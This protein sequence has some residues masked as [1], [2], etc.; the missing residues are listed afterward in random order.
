ME[1]FSDGKCNE[2]LM[3]QGVRPKCQIT[4]A[5]GMIAVAAS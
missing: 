1:N 2:V 4:V 3:S 5:G